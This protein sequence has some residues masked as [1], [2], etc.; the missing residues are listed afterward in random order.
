MNEFILQML[1]CTPVHVWQS[2]GA[3]SG[4]LLARALHARSGGKRL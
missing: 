2:Y 3:P 1:A 4:T